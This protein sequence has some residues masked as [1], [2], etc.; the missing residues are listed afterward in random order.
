MPR[1][2]KPTADHKFIVRQRG[3]VDRLFTTKDMLDRYVSGLLRERPRPAFE[4][5]EL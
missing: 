1:S 4:V 3:T 2:R 5:I